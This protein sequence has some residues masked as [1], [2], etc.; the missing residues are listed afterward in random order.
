V[1]LLSGDLPGAAAQGQRALIGLVQPIANVF[2]YQ[3][4]LAEATQGVREKFDALAVATPGL[5]AVLN[6]LSGITPFPV[7]NIGEAARTLGLLEQLKARLK[8]VQDQRDKETTVP[9]IKIDNAEIISLQKQIAALEGTDKAGKKAL[10][11]ITKLR[12]ELSRLTALDNLLGNTPSQVEVLERRT[13]ALTAGLKTLV[14]AGVST[15]SRAFRGFAA[16]L[17]T[18][19]QALDKI[20]GASGD[21]QLTPA[22]LTGLVPTTIGDTLPRD[23]ARLLGDYAKKPIPFE[24]PVAARLNMQAITDAQQPVQLLSSELL[25]LGDIKIQPKFDGF[26]T[27]PLRNELL[28]LGAAFKQIDGASQ[29]GVLFDEA[30]A[31]ASVLQGAIQNLLANGTGPLDANLQQL[32]AQFKQLSIDAQAT[33]SVKASVMDLASGISEAFANATSG[34]QGIG[35]SLLQTLLSTVGNLATQLGGILL[36]AGLG[37]EALKVSLA[38]F[39]G[40]GA[41]AAGLGLLAIGGIAK[42]AAANIG[43]SAGGAGGGGSPTVSNYGQNSNNTQKIVVEV[44]SRLRGQDLVAI[45]QGNAYRNRVG[46]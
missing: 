39:T 1:K 13:N 44:V 9:A 18:T 38:T 42:G 37:I 40:V 15:S 25:R 19:S 34:M 27:K 36:A 22:K 23:V 14:D 29:L 20:R 8:E 26:V 11:A 12:L 35:D 16:D 33:Q 7:V 46:G 4:R 3:L 28:N 21:L 6:N 43:K 41:I 10:D 30:G 32:S 45:G 2:G 24:L 17:V 31:K 5:A